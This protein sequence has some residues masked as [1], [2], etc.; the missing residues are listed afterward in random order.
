MSGE[1]L[2]VVIYSIIVFCIL[3]ALRAWGGF[4]SAKLTFVGCLLTVTLHL[5]D[6]PLTCLINIT[7]LLTYLL[8]YL[9][10][11]F[12]KSSAILERVSC[13]RRRYSK[14]A[15]SHDVY[16]YMLIQ[17]KFLLSKWF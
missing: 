15:L 12:A 11:G 10:P 17:T 1:Q 16:T 3:Y 8:T 6:V 14:N 2:S 5:V 13:R 7:Y 4:L 9:F